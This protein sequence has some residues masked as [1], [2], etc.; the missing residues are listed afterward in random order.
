M[1]VSQWLSTW[2]T[3]RKAVLRP[4]TI[5]QYQ[6]LID[7][8]IAPAIGDRDLD[9]IG[10]AEICT[11][12]ASIIEA[13]HTR[14]A[15]LVFVLLQA[16]L[17]E[18]SPDLMRRV[19]RP[20]HRQKTP[21]AW[22]DAHMAAYLAAVASERQSLGLTLGIVLGLRRGEICGLRWQDIDFDRQIIRIVN[23]RQR[24]ADGRI[25]DCPPKSFA[26]VRDIPIPDQLLPLLRSRRQLAGYLCPISPSGLDAAHRRL[27]RRLQ[28]PYIPLHGLR[29]SMATACIR[30]GGAMKSLQLLLGHAK[31]ATTADRYTHPD[32]EMLRSA[33]A[34]SS[35]ACYTVIQC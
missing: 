29:H 26:S 20:A 12:L 32:C 10:S 23:Q 34:C 16:A 19:P 5:E 24:M 21:E 15:E 6:D 8:Y 33:L 7:R 27:V 9:R 22:T 3:L 28:L 35:R 11:L 13:G 30:H 14:T 18:I 1:N 25:V 2:L 31:Y 4:R 17:K